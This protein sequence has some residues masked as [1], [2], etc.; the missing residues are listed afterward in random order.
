[1]GVPARANVGAA[2]LGRSSVRFAPNKKAR[3]HATRRVS[4]ERMSEPPGR[5]S[6]RPR[7]ARDPFQRNSYAGGTIFL[8]SVSNCVGL[9]GF[10]KNTAAPHC[11]DSLRAM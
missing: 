10:V 3:G 7:R 6:L 9:N 2:C 5:G 1:M 11:S 8:I 4:F